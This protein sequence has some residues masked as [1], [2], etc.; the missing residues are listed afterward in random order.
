MIFAEHV[1]KSFGASDVISDVSFNIA[2]GQRVALVGPNGVGK[3]TL[4]RLLAGEDMPTSGTAGHRNG[5]LGY[6]KQEVEYNP[7]IGL[8]AEMWTEFPEALEVATRLAVIEKELVESNSLDHG[9]LVE[10]SIRLYERFDRLDGQYVDARV[11]RVLG[12]LGFRKSDYAKACGDFSGGWRMRISL[13]KALVRRPDHLLLDEPTNHLDGKARDWLARELR[14]YTGTLVI[15][16]HDG[17]FLDK[18]VTRILEI[19]LSGIVSYTGNY[20]KYLKEKEK[21]LQ[22]R[23]QAAARQDRQ[24]A[25]QQQF[26]D[27]FRAKA[28]KATQVK[29]REKAIAKVERVVVPRKTE[30]P[31]FRIRAK[32]RV[33][34]QV[35]TMPRRTQRNK[36]L[37][38]T[39]GFLNP[40]L[41]Q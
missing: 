26:I 16:T 24:L 10:E 19:D 41:L 1:T 17:D 39:G 28:T 34:Q 38:S 31:R 5:T 40:T 12:G 23:E 33:E 36:S 13:A 4:L 27:R 14:S 21:R 6:L 11:S 3:T 9:A 37:I 35:L 20:T 22:A 2:D 18:V 32:G 7:A 8:V 29:S 30:S 25:S 15:V